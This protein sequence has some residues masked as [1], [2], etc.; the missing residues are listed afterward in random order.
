MLSLVLGSAT[1]SFELMLSA[2]ILGLA[3]GAFA[4]RRRSDAGAASVRTLALV[5]I[6]MGALAIATLPVYLQ[7]FDWMAALMAAF[8]RTEE[9]YRVFS[10]ARY[11][12]LPRRDASGD[13]LRRHDA[14]ADHAHC[15]SRGGSGER[16]DRA[17]VRR[18]HARLDR[19]RGARRA[20]A[21]AA[22]RA[23][24]A[25]RR[26]RAVDVAARVRC[27]CA[28]PES[29]VRSRRA[30]AGGPLAAWRRRRASSPSSASSHATSTGRCSRAAC[31]AT[32]APERRAA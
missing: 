29:N 30:R 32:R 24:V 1:H 7:S 22:A 25:A 20:R 31:I 19:R 10:V 6:A 16:G 28:L 8:A 14:A 15:C 21:D 2:F 13:L 3:L 18:Q 17:G 4:I 23:Q 9:G 12:H 5:Q 27:C 11:L 26:R